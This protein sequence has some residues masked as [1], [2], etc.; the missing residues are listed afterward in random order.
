MTKQELYVSPVVFDSEHHT[1]TLDG[2]ELSGVTPIISWLFPKTYDGISKSVLN[3]AAEYGT[4]VHQACE[5]ADDMG[6]VN[7]YTKQYTE[8]LKQHGLTTA[9]SEYLVSDEKNIAS[10]IDK[11]FDD[12][13][14]GD[15]KT[16]S[17]I[18]WVNVQVQLSIYA[19]LYEKQTGRKA[20]KL[21]VIWLPKPRYG[22]ATIK[23]IERIPAS[24]CEYV[25]ENYLAKADPLNALSAMSQYLMADAPVKKRKEGEVPEHWQSVID[26]L[27]LVKQQLDKLTEREKELKASVMQGMQ[28]NGDDKWA[29]DLIQ[30]SRVAASERVSIDTKA[31]QSAEPDIYEKYKKTS[32]VAESLRY[33]L[34]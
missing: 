13:S 24:I 15:I 32:K 17:N 28:S 22:E 26:E 31:L 25:V 18:H 19:W 16:T 29:N 12:D 1:Y 3:A 27:I 4:M 11:V 7:E 6:I 10:A 8:L 9:Y 20:N 30:I 21:Y 23:K 2:K 5:L 34:L 33:K 14:M